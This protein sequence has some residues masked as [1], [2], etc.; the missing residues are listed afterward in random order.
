MADIVKNVWLWISPADLKTELRQ[1]G[2]EGRNTGLIERRIEKLV[3]REPDELFLPENQVEAARILDFGQQ[4]PMVEGYPYQ[5]PSDLASIKG[6]RGRGPR[7]YRKPLGDRTL[8]DRI[9]G[10]WIGRCAGC[11]L[12]KPFEGKRTPD[13]WGFLKDTRQ[14]PLRKYARF[15]V[16]GDAAAKYPSMA[17]AAW[18]DKIKDHMPVDDDTNY[19]TTGFLIVRQYGKDFTPA[20]VAQF[21]LG[22]IPLLATCTAERIAYR[23]LALHIQ[24]PASAT[25][26]NPYR[27]WIGAQIRADAFG[28]LA[29]GDPQTAAAWAWRD[30]CISHVKNGIYGEMFAAAAI[31]A[32]PYAETIADVIRAGL[33]EIPQTSRLFARV[34][35]VFDWQSAGLTY[36]DAVAKVHEA[37]DEFEGHDWC[38]T[39][40]NAV[41]CAVALL[42]GEEDFGRSIGMAVQ[43]G[44]DTDCNGATVG[45][46]LG[47]RLG[48]KGIGPEWTGRLNDT[49]R[50][51]LQGYDT[52]QISE[53]ARQ[54]WKLHKDLRG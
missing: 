36:D 22:N 19:T 4:L 18:F 53:I 47:M 37:W 54:T 15:G 27:E 50:T 5:E 28:Y 45:S 31:A 6:L 21:W 46:I 38:H 7:R 41:L 52:V 25:W 23:N 10:A 13:I 24:P 44:F 1:L 32:A 11:L 35:E 40:S 3:E 39:I 51:S 8:A 2:E 16:K 20:D 48:T 12:G 17:K 33:S 42:W 30:A 34:S 49:L 9:H 14:Y 43:C 29:V 26:R